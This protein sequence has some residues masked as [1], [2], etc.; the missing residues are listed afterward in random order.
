MATPTYCTVYPVTAEFFP[1]NSSLAE[2]TTSQNFSLELGP[3]RHRVPRPG[4]ALPP[5]P[6]RPAPPTPPP[7]PSPP[8]PCASTAK[9]ATRPWA[10]STSPCRRAS[11]PDLRGIA[12]CPE[13]AIAAAAQTPG[14]L[15]QA[16]P[17]CP[18]GSADRHL[19]RRRRP[20][21]PPLPRLRQDLLRR[22][23]PGRPA[24]AWSRSP[25]PSPAPMTTAPSSSASPSISTPSTPTSSP[26]PKRCPQ[27][28]GGIPLRMRS[29]QVNIDKPNFM[30]DP[31]NC[32][33]RSIASQGIGDQGTA[34]QLLLSLPAG[35]LLHPA[36]QAEDDGPRQLGARKDT[37]RS[38]EPSPPLRPHHPPRRRQHQIGRRHPVR[39][40]RDRP[41]PPRQ[42]LRRERTR[43]PP[44]AP[45]ARRSAPR[46]PPRR[47]STSRS[48]AP[49]T[50]SPAP[51]ACPASPSSSTA[52]STSFPAPKPKPSRGRLQTTVPGRPRCA[53]RPLPPR[54]LRRQARLPDQHPRSLRPPADH[55]NLLHRAERQE[56]HPESQAQSLLRQG[57]GQ[58]PASLSAPEYGAS[59]ALG[60]AA[61]PGGGC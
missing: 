27:I 35:Q 34:R 9:T 5:Q 55:R 38:V 13:A 12:Y 30:I 46:P 11:P 59:L 53:D 26:T 15:E 17:S 36:L 21:H 37:R 32:D 19:Q 28:I 45:G 52:R 39:R 3:P 58:A 10:S 7:A 48:P 8:S 51:A 4:P 61:G 44:S 2:Q 57:A 20:R 40:L 23:L 42:P 50:P 31:T 47:C 22:P 56:P 54:P 33:A 60:R 1:W 29:I 49:S 18:A 41:A 14:R 43:S 25:R 24:S 6:S 16:S